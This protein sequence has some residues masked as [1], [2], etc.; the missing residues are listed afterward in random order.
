MTIAQI[1]LLAGGVV[2]SIIALLL[3]KAILNLRTV[4]STND[5]HIL[6]RSGSTTS[7]GKDQAGGNV[8]YAWPAWLPFI[9]CTV[10]RCRC[11]CST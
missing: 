4:V 2:G 1:A 5:V 9:G 7:F 6:Q 3:I 8:Y 11:T 10:I